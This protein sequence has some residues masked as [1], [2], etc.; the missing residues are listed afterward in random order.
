MSDGNTLPRP[1]KRKPLNRESKVC[2]NCGATFYRNENHWG[3][4]WARAR[5]CGISCAAKIAGRERRGT[6]AE[7]FAARYKIAASGCWE[8]TGQ[9]T[10]DG[11]G[12][13]SFAGVNCLAHRM[14]YELHKTLPGDLFVCHRCDNPSCVNP[15]HLFLGTTQDNTADMVAKGR[16][17]IGQKNGQAILSDEQV[18]A[19]KECS[20]SDDILGR[21]C[22]VSAHTIYLI[23]SGRAWKKVS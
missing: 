21:L 3:Q 17:N 16:N 23:R 7:Y 14:S 15:D 4:R 6:K 9:R 20:L 8:W 5:G 11:Y 2:E 12:R 10:E 19:I 22:G 13:T 18:R 1:E